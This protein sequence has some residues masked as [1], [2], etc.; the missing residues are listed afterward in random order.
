M[1]DSII[2]SAAGVTASE[3][4]ICSGISLVFGAIIALAHSYKNQYSKSMLL[5]LVVLPI[6]IQTILMLVNGNIGAGIAVLGA[7]S[8][9]RFRSQPGNSREISSIFLATAVGTA[10]ALGFVA[11]AAVLL[12]AVVIVT[13]VMVKLGIGEKGAD[14]HLRITI[15]ENLDYE[16]LFD[17]I[18]D[19]F[20]EKCEM[21]KVKTVN[22]G[23]LYEL[24]YD[25][26]MK[27]DVKEKEFLDALR[28]RNG[29]LNIILSKVMTVRDEL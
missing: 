13:V 20:T 29:N 2:S 10:M 6:V 14:K 23:S 24:D 1:F 4:L 11:V 8:L 18:F 19:A 5:T 26:T 16:G 22:M 7:F 27:K 25:L 3:F 15:P 9:I 12:A 21:T 28:C 17:D